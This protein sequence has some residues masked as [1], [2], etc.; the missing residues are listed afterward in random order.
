MINILT[1][2]WDQIHTASQRQKTNYFIFVLPSF[3]SKHSVISVEQYG[4]STEQGLVAT[5]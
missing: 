2:Y 5:V 1:E 4:Q 3:I